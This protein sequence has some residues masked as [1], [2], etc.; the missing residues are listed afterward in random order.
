MTEKVSLLPVG[1][2]CRPLGGCRR[3]VSFGLGQTHIASEKTL[4]GAPQ[5][6]DMQERQVGLE[7]EAMSFLAM[8]AER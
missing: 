7:K 3:I 4:S 8:R 1:V 6:Y 2:S 5:F